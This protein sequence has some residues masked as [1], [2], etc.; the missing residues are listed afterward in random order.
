[1][2]EPLTTRSAELNTT[3]LGKFTDDMQVGLTWH[4]AIQ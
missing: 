1:M 3:L 2:A 4:T